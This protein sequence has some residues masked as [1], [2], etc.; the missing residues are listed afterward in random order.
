MSRYRNGGETG[1]ARRARSRDRFSRR[2]AEHWSEEYTVVSG[3]AVPARRSIAVHYGGALVST[4]LP[5]DPSGA[6]SRGSRQ[7]DLPLEEDELMRVAQRVGREE[8]LDDD[9]DSSDMGFPAPAEPFGD[10]LLAGAVGTTRSLASVSDS[11]ERSSDRVARTPQAFS[12]GPMERVSQAA[13]R[14]SPLI[15]V[16]GIGLGGVAGLLFLWLLRALLF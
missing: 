8:R 5:G 12:H 1:K 13:P 2:V 16:V 3:G 9:P 14:L 11:T 6:A 15:L 10:P 7:L 4:T